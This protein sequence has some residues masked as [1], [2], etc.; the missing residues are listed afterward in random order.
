MYNQSLFNIFQCVDITSCG[1]FGVIGY[2]S[3]HVDMYNLQSGIHRGSY[4]DPGRVLSLYY[5][6]SYN[7]D[8]D[9]TVILLLPNF[10]NQVILQRNDG[11]M[12]YNSF[13]KLSFYNTVHLSGRDHTEFRG[14]PLSRI[15][16]TLN[17]LEGSSF[18]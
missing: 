16:M 17:F 1:N 5:T 13:V 8:L 7:I 10:F 2:S 14:L 4:G 12:T 3:G 6:H 15:F 18:P 9:I 11:E